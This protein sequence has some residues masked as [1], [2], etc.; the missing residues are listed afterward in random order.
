MTQH[1]RQ[2]IADKADGKITKK[3]KTGPEEKKKT[4]S[5]GKIAK[6]M[7][8]QPKRV[9]KTAPKHPAGGANK[10]TSSLRAAMPF[11]GKPKAEQEAMEYKDFKVYTDVLAGTW[12]VK[13]VGQRKD[14]SASFKVDPEGAWAKVL[15]ILAGEQ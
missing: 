9:I 4:G 11:P 13:R 1:I 14:R 10:V 12:R 6:A 7:K 2:L 15:K 8:S 5:Q 3:E